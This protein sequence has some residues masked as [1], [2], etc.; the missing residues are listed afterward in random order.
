MKH[1]VPSFAPYHTAT[2]SDISWQ[3]LAYALETM[4]GRKFED[5]LRD[6]VLKP[7]GLDH[8]FLF[9]PDAELGII[10]DIPEKTLS[11]TGWNLSLG[12]GAA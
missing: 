8:T 11:S 10:P 6:D 5:M 1:V 2:Y 12:E 4:K 3:I 7:L 9:A